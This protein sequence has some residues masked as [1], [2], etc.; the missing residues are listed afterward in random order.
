MLATN[1]M[2][3]CLQVSVTHL[4]Y[5]TLILLWMYTEIISRAVTQWH[6]RCRNWQCFLV[7][8]LLDHRCALLTDNN[9]QRNVQDLSNNKQYQTALVLSGCDLRSCVATS[10]VNYHISKES[11]CPCLRCSWAILCVPTLTQEHRRN[12]SLAGIG[13]N[14]TVIWRRIWKRCVRGYR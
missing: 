2:K 5:C 13:V 12:L 6:I 10:E 14:P 7:N 9:W 8:C 3:Q 1:F 11:D 4:Q